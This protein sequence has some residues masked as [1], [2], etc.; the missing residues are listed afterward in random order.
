MVDSAKA[1][2][3]VHLLDRVEGSAV[4]VGS[5]GLEANANV[6]DW[7]RDERVADSG[8]CAGEVVLPK[9]ERLAGSVALTANGDR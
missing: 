4:D 2:S 8:A 9:R 7:A 6:L 1:V 5:L 3:A